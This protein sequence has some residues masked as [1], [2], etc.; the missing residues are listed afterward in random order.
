MSLGES[1]AQHHVPRLRGEELRSQTGY[2][3][4]LDYTAAGRLWPRPIAWSSSLNVSEL[5]ML[6][7]TDITTS[8]PIRP[9]C[10]GGSIDAN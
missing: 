3:R 9:G 2:R 5:N 10:T 7:L 4:R 6:W 8:A 1:C